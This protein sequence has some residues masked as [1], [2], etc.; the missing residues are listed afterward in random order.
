MSTR[1]LFIMKRKDL[2]N[3]EYSHHGHHGG[4]GHGGDRF[5]STVSTGLLNSITQMDTALNGAGYNVKSVVVNDNNDIDREVTSFRPDIVIIEALWVVPTKFEVLKRLHP[6]VKWVVRLHSAIPFLQNEGIAIDWIVQ[7]MLWPN[8]YVSCNDIRTLRSLQG[9]LPLF[10]DKFFY[11]PNVC[12]EPFSE[13]ISN[14]SWDK[15]IDIGCFGST[16]PLKNQLMQALAAIRFADELGK[17]LRFHINGS[18]RVEQ[19]G[20]PVLRNLIALFEWS[21]R[22]RLIEHPWLEHEDFVDLCATMGLGM[23]VSLSETFNFVSVDL[24]ASGVPVVTSPEIT[25][26]PRTLKADPTNEDEIVAALWRAYRHPVAYVKRARRNLDA[27]S[28]ANLGAWLRSIEELE[29]NR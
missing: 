2:Y 26:T 6:R 18:S 13:Y 1:I 28:R 27:L 23:Q 10:R 20:A 17:S 21:G 5:V 11:Q 24:V 3:G 8:V 22:H 19:L 16:R 14:G 12:E 7:Y 4:H 9:Y 25:W 15:H 29:D